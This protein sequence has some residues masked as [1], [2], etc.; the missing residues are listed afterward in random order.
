[1]DNARAVSCL[2]SSSDI[3]PWVCL[4]GGYSQVER[5]LLPVFSASSRVGDNVSGVAEMAHS[6]SLPWLEVVS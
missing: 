4:V 2:Y 5:R 3:C 1:M 6:L